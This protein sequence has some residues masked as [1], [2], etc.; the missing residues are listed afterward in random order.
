MEK[1]IIQIT[2]GKGPAEC[3]RVVVRVQQMMQKQA[4]QQGINLQVLENR[5]GEIPGALHSSTM[6][7]A[8][9]NLATFV[10]EWAGTIQ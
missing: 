1:V 8:G 6:Q 9:D 10:K 4:K 7:A 2:S 5:I 3:R